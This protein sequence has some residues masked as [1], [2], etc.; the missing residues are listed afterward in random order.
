[1]LSRNKIEPDF[2]VKKPKQCLVQKP[3]Q[4]AFY[5]EL[6]AVVIMRKTIASLLILLFVVSSVSVSS[7]LTVSGS[8]NDTTTFSAITM[9]TFPSNGETFSKP[10]IAGGFI[11][12]TS[13]NT[14]TC[15]DAI[16]GTQVWT[17]KPCLSAS[18]LQTV[19]FT[20]TRYLKE[21][22]KVTFPA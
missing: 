10:V 2:F 14:I 16:T 1:M 4:T 17:A 19:M 11:Y 18:Q 6:F 22:L 3:V 9:W 21:A 5:S 8:T 20:S 15:I 13:W 7:A 12:I